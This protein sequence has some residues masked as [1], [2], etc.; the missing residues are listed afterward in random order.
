MT[1]VILTTTINAPTDAIRKFDALPDWHLIVV[2]DKRTPAYKLERGRFIPWQEVESLYPELVKLVGWNCTQLG[3]MVG[4]LEARKH[5]P[6]LVAT[7]DD[8][9]NPYPGWPG[10]I[11]VGRCVSAEAYLC[12]QEVF[13]P[14]LCAGYRHPP[15]GFPPQ[16]RPLG[17]ESSPRQLNVL[18]QENFWDGEIDYDAC[19]RVH[20]STYEV[21][22]CKEPFWSNGMSPVN[23]QNTI[24]DGSV[25]RDY[26][27][28]L[29]F[30][31]HV[32]D[33]WAGYLFQAWHPN[34]TLYAPA[35]VRHWQDRSVDSVVQDLQDEIYSY[36]YTLDFVR[37]LQEHGPD[38]IHRIECVPAGTVKAIDIYR[39]YF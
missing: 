26:C 23:T 38:R 29:P 5:S 39:G 25:L 15:R 13:N 32:S 31:G 10:D 4:F 14:F 9:C 8:D 6:K 21:C 33:I 12:K 30:V 18:V 36:K 2:G 7:I 34:S 17:Y 24:I 28:E 3:R 35:N 11:Y 27:G 37:G 20:G 19:W 22:T 1:N 16:L